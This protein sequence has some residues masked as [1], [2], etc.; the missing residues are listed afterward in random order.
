MPKK[1]MTFED[2]MKRL[3]EITELL[4]SSQTSIDEAIQ[5]FEEGSRI[6]AECSQILKN[7]ELKVKKFEGESDN[8]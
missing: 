3:D 4:E 8:E 1:K 2:S 7:A 5:F 6:A